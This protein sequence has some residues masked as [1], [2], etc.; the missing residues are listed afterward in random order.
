MTITE[1][2]QLPLAAGNWT[3]DAAHSAVSF[4]VR[5]LGISKV[6]GRFNQVDASLVVG[7]S[8]ASTTVSA[9]IDMA[10]VDTNNPDRDAHLQGTDFFNAEAHPQLTFASTRVTASPEGEYELAGELSL[11]GVTAPITLAVEFNG[12]EVFPMDQQTHAGFTATGT[13]HRSAY[14]VDFNVPLGAD[15]VMLSDKI[16]IELDL[17]FVAPTA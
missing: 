5:H 10:S 13:V 11:N 8:L 2:L 3:F 1:S 9:S 16:N 6:R 14:G 7:E 4:S 12:V 17:Q 15:K